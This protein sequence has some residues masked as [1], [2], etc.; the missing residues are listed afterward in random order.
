MN[1]RSHPQ[2]AERAQS[3]APRVLCPL[4]I[5]PAAVSSQHDQGAAATACRWNAIQ[6]RRQALS[7]AEATR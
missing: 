4:T 6:I 7:I 1:A 2:R 5:T 3:S